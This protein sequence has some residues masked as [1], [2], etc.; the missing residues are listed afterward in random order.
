[1]RLI[2]TIALLLISSQAP[3][4]DTYVNGYTKQDGTW[5]A[6]HY[7]TKPDNN[8]FN[9]YSSQGNVNPYTGKAG[10]IDPYETQQ[11]YGQKKHRKSGN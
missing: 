11:N 6:P 2:L 1:M 8:A 5:V 9:N 4:A 7:Q 3:A 10:T